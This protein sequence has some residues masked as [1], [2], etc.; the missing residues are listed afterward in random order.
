M[1]PLVTLA[2]LGLTDIGITNTLQGPPY[3]QARNGTTVIPSYSADMW[4]YICIFAELYM[5]ATGFRRLGASGLEAVTPY[6][7][8]SLRQGTYTG[9]GDSDSSWYDPKTMAKHEFS[10]ETEF[11]KRVQGGPRGN[12]LRYPSYD[13]ASPIHRIIA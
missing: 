13:A 4:S 10:L 9:P 11:R 7:V 12:S 3:Y 2:N 1:A 8:R 5:G 6:S